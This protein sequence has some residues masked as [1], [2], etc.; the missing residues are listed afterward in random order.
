MLPCPLY[1]YLHALCLWQLRGDP[2]PSWMSLKESDKRLGRAVKGTPGGWPVPVGRAHR[3]GRCFVTEIP[4][5]CISIGLFLLGQT[6]WIVKQSFVRAPS[7]WRPIGRS[8]TQLPRPEVHPPSSAR[9]RAPPR[10]P[11]SEMRSPSTCQAPGGRR[12]A[13]GV[14]SGFEVNSTALRSLSREIGKVV[15]GRLTQIPGL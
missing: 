14:D 10:G 11:T 15:T 9:S 1:L 8:A 4:S 6:S 3:L 13:R 5:N 12:G 2:L 7:D